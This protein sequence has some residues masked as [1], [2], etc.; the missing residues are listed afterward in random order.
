MTLVASAAFV[1]STALDASAM[2]IWLRGWLAAFVA[3]QVFEAPVHAT[4]LGWAWRY[5]EAS[6]SASNATTAAASASTTAVANGRR[7]LAWAGA[8]LPSSITHT[9][10]WFVFPRVLPGDWHLMVAAAES[11]AVIAEA[12]ILR[13]LAPRL[14]VAG[15]LAISLLANGASLGLGLWL[16]ATTGWV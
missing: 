16:R 14:G 6:E 10:V 13:L 4:A 8:L 11:F 9:V 1:A 3:T 15:A 12:L 2:P 5:T 7:A